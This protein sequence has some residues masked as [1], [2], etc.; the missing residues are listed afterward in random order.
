MGSR[1]SLVDQ[2]VKN[3]PTMWETWIQSLGWEDPLE[4]G[5]ATHSSILAW[6]IPWIE[7]LVG[8]SP[9]HCKVSGVTGENWS[10]C[11]SPACELPVR[12]AKISHYPGLVERQIFQI[13]HFLARCGWWTVTPN[14]DSPYLVTC[15]GI[16]YPTT[17]HF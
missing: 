7:E 4:Q 12:W 17:E 11:G 6:R 13:L 9:W 8:H 5:M 10:F 16:L 15:P 1:A 3:L 14:L 2:M